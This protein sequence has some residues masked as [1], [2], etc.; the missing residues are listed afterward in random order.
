ML[1]NQL[2][3]CPGQPP[4]HY[5]SRKTGGL[6]KNPEREADG[7]GPGFEPLPRFGHFQ[8]PHQSPPSRELVSKFIT[9]NFFKQADS[10]SLIFISILIKD[11]KS[12]TAEAKV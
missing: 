8:A 12:I 1:Q 9:E 11:K 3:V 5:R 2:L 4:E 7:L 10:L 6:V